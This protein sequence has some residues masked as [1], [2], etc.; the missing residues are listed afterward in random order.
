MFYY[1]RRLLSLAILRELLRFSN[2][3][4]SITPNLFVVKRLNKQDL[5]VQSFCPPKN[6]KV[7]FFG[8]PQLHRFARIKRDSRG[9]LV[10]LRN[11]SRN[12]KQQQRQQ[13]KRKT[14]R[15]N[16]SQR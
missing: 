15:R 11:Q 2:Q 10:S 1:H 9:M 4:V 16:G 6:S 3:A 14:G 12:N 7:H 8:S 13:Q 5:D